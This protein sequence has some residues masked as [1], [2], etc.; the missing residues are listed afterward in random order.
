[1]TEILF[2][3]SS[4]EVMQLA[5]MDYSSIERRDQ[6]QWGFSKMYIVN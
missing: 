1:M 3:T 6:T 2:S 5:H 4:E